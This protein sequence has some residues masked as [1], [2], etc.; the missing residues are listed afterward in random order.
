MEGFTTQGRSEKRKVS[1]V[2]TGLWDGIAITNYKAI[3]ARRI[4][5]ECDGSYSSLLKTPQRDHLVTSGVSPC[6]AARPRLFSE[7]IS[8]P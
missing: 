6:A 1:I 4:A 8:S 5:G 3:E 2:G 7:P